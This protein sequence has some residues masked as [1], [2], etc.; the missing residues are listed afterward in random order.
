MKKP[1]ATSLQ[2]FRLSSVTAL[3]LSFGLVGAVA[4]SLDDVSQ[5]PPGDPSAYS[6]PPAD[7]VAAA[8][9]LE[10]LKSMP[11]ANE[12]SLELSNGVYGDR[13]TVTTDNVL[14]PAQ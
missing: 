14:Q 9:A 4:G 6:D 8:A 10:A 7:P 13:S 5:P 1:A 2:V 12:G 11:E 3:L